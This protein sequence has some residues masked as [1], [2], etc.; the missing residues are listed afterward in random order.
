MSHTS[1]FSSL[2]RVFQIPHSALRSKPNHVLSSQKTPFSTSATLAAGGHRPP[3]DRRVT[4]IRYALHHPYRYTPR[5]L[6]FSRNRFL[7]HWTITRAW[8]LFSAKQKQARGLELE[9][10]YNAMRAACEELR[11]GAGDGGR[12]YRQAMSKKGVWGGRSDLGVVANA[13]GNVLTGERGRV[14][15]GREAGIPI[16]Y[17]RGLTD[18]PPRGGFDEEWKR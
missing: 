12:L 3:R 2:A 10:Q 6:R 14:E 11:V 4:M 15:R 18:G 16:E 9:R 7:R 17:G 13:E 1:L 5:P 8:S